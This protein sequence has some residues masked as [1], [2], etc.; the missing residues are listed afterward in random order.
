M[1]RT[2]ETIIVLAGMLTITGCSTTTRNTYQEQ[3]KQQ[4]GY[5]TRNARNQALQISNEEQDIPT[6]SETLFFQQ[7]TPEEFIYDDWLL[8]KEERD[9]MKEGGPLQCGTGDYYVTFKQTEGTRMYTLKKHSI[10]NDTTTYILDE[11]LQLIESAWII[12]G[13]EAGTRRYNNNTNTIGYNST[14]TDI[15]EKENNKEEEQED[16]KE[17]QRILEQILRYKKE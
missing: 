3:Q 12:L 6:S 9:K 2:I 17:V 16:K 1:G 4:E 15:T 11:H 5:T 7:H 10:T 13:N 8:P 14:G